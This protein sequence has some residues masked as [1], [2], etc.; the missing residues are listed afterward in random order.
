MAD[1]TKGNA[2]KER[3]YALVLDNLIA[4]VL[5]FAALVVTPVSN[6]YVK[7]AVIVLVYLGYFLVTEG[8][9][10]Q[11]IG[12]KLFGLRVVRLNGEPGGFREAW[13]RTLLRL[14]EVNP[15][16]FGYLPA[17]LT[18]IATE[19]NQ[20]LGDLAAGTLVIRSGRR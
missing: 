9:W 8:F 11:T 12:K 14:L 3:I 6:P 7:I 4:I 1:T 16:L 2:T 5:A 13:I 19:R 18:V 15:F 10:A 17:G 20:R